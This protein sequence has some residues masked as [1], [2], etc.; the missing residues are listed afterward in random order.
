MKQIKTSFLAFRV[1]MGTLILEKN[2]KKMRG[3]TTEIVHISAN[4]SSRELKSKPNY[5]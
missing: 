2:D 3:Y 4:K 1:L 5:C